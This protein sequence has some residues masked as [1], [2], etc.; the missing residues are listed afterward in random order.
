MPLDGEEDVP[1]CTEQVEEV[2]EQASSGS[3]N[4]IAKKGKNVD[5]SEGYIRRGGHHYGQETVYVQV[6]AEVVKGH[7]RGT[8]LLGIP[9][10][11][12]NMNHV[13]D[14]VNDLPNGIYIGFTAF[15]NEPDVV[16]MTVA[17]IGYNPYFKN[18][19]KTV[20]PHILHDFKG[21]TFYGSRLRVILC[22]Y[23]RPELPF[24]SLQDLI[25]AINADIVFARR[26]LL[27]DRHAH[28][29]DEIRH[30]S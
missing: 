22:G 27:K 3:Q 29:K 14:V 20:E 13:G 19:E 4:R 28:F 1:A 12:L 5:A 25:V 18:V 24:Y 8:K 17:S 9:T 16:Y 11:N 2:N 7:G 6:I 21:D 15:D 26:E 30:M 23:V 10:A